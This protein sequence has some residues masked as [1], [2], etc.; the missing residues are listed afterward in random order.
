M[1]NTNRNRFP[2]TVIPL[3]AC[4]VAEST[5]AKGH[6]VRMLDLLFEKYPEAALGKAVHDF[7]PDILG[8]SVRNIDNNDMQQPVSYIKE[9]VP[10]VEVIKKSTRAP[11]VLGGTAIGIMPEEILRYTG[12]TWAVMGNGVTVFPEVINALERGNGPG[13]I[14][15]LAWIENGQFHSNPVCTALPSDLC[16]LPDFKRWLNMKKYL[17]CLSTIPIRSKCGCPFKC[18]YCTYAMNGGPTH[19]M[20]TPQSVAEV[21]GYCVRQGFRNIEFVDN[22]FNAPYE[23][24][25]AICRELDKVRPRANLQTLELNPLYIDDALLTAMEN[26]GFSAIGITPE[27]V[28]DPVLDNLQKG[29]TAGHVHRAA[30]CVRRHHLPC[31]W[32]FMFGG[33]G[34]TPATVQQ[35]L[36]F[37]AKSIHPRDIAF[38]SVGIRIYPGTQLE[39]IARRQNILTKPPQDMLDPVFYISPEIDTA[40]LTQK[41]K[42]AMAEHYHFLDSTSLSLPLIP[43]VCR[44][45]FRLGLK[46]PVWIHTRT[47]RRTMRFLGLNV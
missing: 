42:T 3:G 13:S 44:L 20:Y 47:L 34:E 30:E 39:K 18:I 8:L 19:Q 31:V 46:P 5:E 27:S 26:A 7:K 14:P 1:V 16:V 6:E 35:T 32:I 17:S 37:A 45:A 15:G 22:V 36:D 25:L 9:L 43:W 28:C 2:V 11:I 40:W 29:F 23:H 4:L 12:T 24:A 38:F 33:P 41:I 10:V 21:V